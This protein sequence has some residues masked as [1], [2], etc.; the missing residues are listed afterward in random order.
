M[1]P[2]GWIADK[3]AIKSP[4]CHRTYVWHNDERSASNKRYHAPPQTIILSFIILSS[5]ESSTHCGNT[6]QT[7][8]KITKT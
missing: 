5:S 2:G 1:Q 7:D 3:T 8:D 4:A 6:R